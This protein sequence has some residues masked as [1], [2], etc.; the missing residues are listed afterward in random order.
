MT[1]C[2]I[3]EDDLHHQRMLSALLRHEGYSV[4]AFSLAEPAKK[5]F[6]SEKPEMVILDLG[7]PDQDGM[8]LIPEFLNIHPETRI[9][10]LSGSDSVRKA[11][12]AL[13]LGARHYLVKP[14]DNDELLIILERQRNS[15][16]RR[17]LKL[18]EQGNCLSCP[19]PQMRA[20]EHTVKKLS[21]SPDTAV[22][23]EGETGT[24]KEVLARDIH[25]RTKPRGDFVA[26]NCAALP[27]DLIESELF[28]HEKGAFTGAA[29]R[30]RGLIELAR[31]G[32]LLLDELTEMPLVLQSK[33]LRFLQEHRYRRVGDHQERDCPCRVIATTNRPIEQALIQQ[34]LRPDLFYR[35]AVVHL[36]IPPLR[37]RKQ[38][39]PALATC[40]LATIQRS[41]AMAPKTLSPA[42]QAALM[43]YSWPGNIRELKNR[44]ERAVVLST[45][46]EILPGDLDLSFN[47]CQEQASSAA[48]N[49]MMPL[50]DIMSAL[51]QNE[52]NVSM[53]A[54]KLNIPRHKLR[55]LIE[56]HAGRS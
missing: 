35:L 38:D 55:Y 50:P 11:V 21:Q 13:H 5:Q 42:C 8:T 41:I 29:S 37:E 39:I 49:D 56:K 14:H 18:R 9:I 20:I 1:L 43:D 52:G 40:L 32:T 53:T 19:S 54:R 31:H 2:Y 36:I 51:D 25:Q 26:F 4:H 22:F 7:L 45:G 10:V 17:E 23:I 47:A 12:E 33:L 6:P 48:T 46:P 30:K 16:N 27:G 44:I 15:L 34:L 3:I 28:G 24:G